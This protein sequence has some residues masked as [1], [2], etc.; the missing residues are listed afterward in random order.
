MSQQVVS[1][2]S[3]VQ[4]I[5]PILHPDVN[6]SVAVLEA[7]NF[8]QHLPPLPPCLALPSKDLLSQHHMTL[9]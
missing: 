7:S 9:R 2:D 3:E 8:P 6:M 1:W 5:P 4:D